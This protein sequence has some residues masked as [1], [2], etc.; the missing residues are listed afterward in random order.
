[1]KCVYCGVVTKGTYL[2]DQCHEKQLRE[3]IVEDALKVDI[4]HPSNKYF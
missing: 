2:C 4:E 3:K 1:M